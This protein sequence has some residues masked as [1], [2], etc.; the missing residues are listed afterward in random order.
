LCEHD[1]IVALA[2]PIGEA[3]IGIVRLSGQGC[4]ELVERFFLPRKKGL[5]L[6]Q[7]PSH[8]VHLGFMCDPDGQILDEVLVNVMRA[9]RT[10]TREDVVEVY[11]HGG[12]I[13]VRAVLR[14][15]LDHGA[16]LAEPGEFTKRAF[17]NGRIDL[18]QAEAVLDVIRSRTEKSALIAVT[19][20]RGV[21]S[22]R[23]NSI[24]DQLRSL[25]V[26]VEAEIDFPDDVEDLGTEERLEQ[27]RRLRAELEGMVNSFRAGKFY[28]E[29]LATAIVGKPNV[30]KSTLLNLFLGEERA[31]VTDIPGTT[32]DLL[33]EVVDI[34]G[35]PIRLIDTAGIRQHGDLVEKI[36]IERACRV[37]EDADLIIAL[38][39]AET[40]LTEEDFQVLELVQG[41]NA[42]LVI[43]KID[44]P[45][46][47]LD[48]KSLQ[49]EYKFPVVEI[50]A[51][52]G[53]GFEELKNQ[54][55]AAV[56][57]GIAGK[58]SFLVTNY[59]H[60]TA[61]KKALQ[62]VQEAEQALK[63]GLP[64]DC[65]AVDLWAAWH[66]L[67]EITGETVSEEVI[68]AIFREFCIGK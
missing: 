51:K 3:A 61:L 66:A 22:Q 49:Q 64:L 9:P 4:V 15:F 6:S 23:I 57:E 16:R 45:H 54:I 37:I 41:K 40:G 48:R 26:Y 25:I 52:L 1:I 39:D 58:E 65:L 29:G 27:L 24:R 63:I 35:I 62:S 19:N 43:N 34:Q 21:L 31:I 42:L 2:T 30:G 10:Y 44:S 20:I 32:R 28:R 11:C 17:L 59:R 53:W 46:R 18:A 60:Y 12:V 8:T 36:G 5:R 55:V 50:S 68:D 67:G 14:L 33:E 7:V 47:T 38:L 56:G 13:P